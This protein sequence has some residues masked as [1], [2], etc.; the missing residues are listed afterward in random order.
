MR[1]PILTIKAKLL[2]VLGAIGVL[3]VAVVAGG[4]GGTSSMHASISTIYADRVVPLRDLKV[5]A[6]LYAVNIVDTSHKVRNDN[7]AWNDGLRS[8]AEA[9][10]EIAKRWS[11][12]MATYMDPAEKALAGKAEERMRAADHS[13]ER[14]ATILKG[15][16][17]AALATFTMT[18]LYAAIDP[19]SEV[20]GK[21]VD[22]QL[23]VAKS[24]AEQAA[25]TF[26]N[27][28]LAFLIAAIVALLSLAWACYAVVAGVSRPLARITTQMNT[29]AGGR[30]LGRGHRFR[31]GRRDR[32]ARPCPRDLQGRAAGQTADRRGGGG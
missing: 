22:L 18:E 16:E 24:E 3:L 7:L 2:F 31:E 26:A 28:K 5:V 9:K 30:P 29:L 6:D 13:V 32:R 23:D 21:L 17:R 4:W 15:E 8:V 25:G 1:S 20:L 11:A 14:L 19:V 12:Y 27:L 10:A